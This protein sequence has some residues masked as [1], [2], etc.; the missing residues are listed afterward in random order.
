MVSLQ[1][2][3][4]ITEGSWFYDFI[5][6]YFFMMKGYQTMETEEDLLT[7]LQNKVYHPQES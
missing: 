5:W 3:P 2:K 6:N 4:V 1:A 7:C